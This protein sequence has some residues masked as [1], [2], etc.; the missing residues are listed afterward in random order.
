MVNKDF[1]KRN[2]NCSTKPRVAGCFREVQWPMMMTGDNVI[3]NLRAINRI[4]VYCLHHFYVAQIS[5]DLECI[6]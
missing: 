1:Q 2:K 3:I 5:R 4:I 6:W